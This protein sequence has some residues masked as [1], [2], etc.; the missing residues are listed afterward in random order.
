[1]SGYLQ[2]ISQAGRQVSTEINPDLGRFVSKNWRRERTKKF[3]KC[4][5]NF[6]MINSG[7][8]VTME[9]S[10]PVSWILYG[11]EKSKMPTND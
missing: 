4:L 2:Q 1:M 9:K 10:R 3:I 5:Q 6:V 7:R 8:I 11:T